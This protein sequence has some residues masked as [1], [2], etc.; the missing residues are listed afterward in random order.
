SLL[1]AGVVGL[2]QSRCSVS[3]PWVPRRGPGACLASSVA[4]C[5]HPAGGSGSRV[6][7]VRPPSNGVE[8]VGRTTGDEPTSRHPRGAGTREVQVSGQTNQ[9][10]RTG[11]GSFRT[12]A[13]DENFPVAVR[14][15][16]RSHRGDLLA[17]YRYAR[18]VDDTGDEAVGDR[19]RLLDGLESQLDE[20]FAGGLPS[21]PAVA[22]LRPT[23]RN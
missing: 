13:Q 21:D 16:P 1:L 18:R 22:G 6:P 17:L 15:L 11:G 10:A 7:R 5:G 8:H 14:L 9:L 3:Q 23:I 20:V 12:R 4:V 19:L 2:C